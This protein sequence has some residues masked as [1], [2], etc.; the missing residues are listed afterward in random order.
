MPEH[1]LHS[2]PGKV[3]VWLDYCPAERDDPLIGGYDHDQSEGGA[4][5]GL[6]AGLA[7]GSFAASFA[8]LALASARALGVESA[9]Y[10]FRLFDVALDHPPGPFGEGVF[11]GVF[12]YSREPGPGDPALALQACSTLR[13]LVEGQWRH[14][15]TFRAQGVALAAAGAQLLAET[16]G[17][18]RMTTLELINTQIGDE[19]AAALAASPH[20]AE[21]TSLDLS[22]NELG[23][24]GLRALAASRGLPGVRRLRLTANRITGEGLAALDASSSLAGVVE[25]DVESNYQLGGGAPELEPAAGLARSALRLET[26]KISNCDLS[27]EG[28]AAL[29]GSPVGRAL[30]E[31]EA[32]GRLGDRS[33]RALGECALLRRFK[34]EGFQET[35][36][37]AWEALTRA[38]RLA[39]LDLSWGQVGD[40]GAQALAAG[41]PR[42][43][44]LLLTSAKVGEAGAVALGAARWLG[45]EE[46]ALDYNAIGDRGVEALVSGPLAEGLR[47]LVLSK[48]EGVSSQAVERLAEAAALTGLEELTL[49]GWP[50]G[51]EGARLLAASPHLTHL[52]ELSLRDAGVGDAG[53]QALLEA[54]QLSRLR[55]LQLAGNPLSPEV[56]DALKQRY[57]EVW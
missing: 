31:L 9:D 49:N 32:G 45:L 39:D 42:L 41:L 56:K 4:A 52:R 5:G 17:L 50:V 53:A 19:G 23:D 51:D 10:V 15:R 35:T 29:L 38:I 40:A 27:D 33:L 21:L 3:S 24:A 57:D 22:S 25:L 43:R 28:L 14:S 8:G 47:V 6:A 46:L 12:D 16:E 34:G 48:N 26:L 1:E 11:L 13:R 7:S 30:R 54:P 20:T 44:R 55:R 37:A 36:P 2:A 18:A